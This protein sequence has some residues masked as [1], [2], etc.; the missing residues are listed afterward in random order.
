MLTFLALPVM[1]EQADSVCVVSQ[2]EEPAK[3]TNILQK[4]GNVVSGVFDYIND[5]DT[6]YIRPQEFNWAAMAEMNSYIESYKL[7]SESGQEIVFSPENRTKIG[8]YAG[9]RWAFLGYTFDIKNFSSPSAKDWSFCFYTP[10]CSIDLIWRKSSDNYKIRKVSLLKDVDALTFENLSLKG[11]ETAVRGV[12]VQY[13]FNHRKFSYPAAF[14]QSSCQKKSA[15]SPILGLGYVYHRLKIDH[16]E[17]STTLVDAV[18]KKQPLIKDYIELD[19]TIRF[20]KLE[21]GAL[22]ISGGYAYNYVPMKNLLL[23]GSVTAGISFK[24]AFS[25]IE[26][27]SFSYRDFK[28]NNV[29]FDG[30]GRFAIV[31][32]NMRWFAGCSTIWHY[33][34]YTR[35]QFHTSNA[36]GSISLYAGINFHRRKEFRS[37][38]KSIW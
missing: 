3:K 17:L 16:N 26:S 2:E 27:E 6:T 23:S 1:A 35:D 18:V 25:D 4:L 11:M 14:A 33:Y 29:N 30:C 34:S 31:Y 13:V 37:K 32:N 28:I 20:N 21:L 10:I 19:T 8:P 9:W 12:D 36:L 22:T 15:G 38:S 5:V 7:K 24:K